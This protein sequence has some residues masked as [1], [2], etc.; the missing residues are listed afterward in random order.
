MCDPSLLPYTA[1][2]DDPARRKSIIEVALHPGEY[3][4]AT[5]GQRISTLLGSCVAIT[6]WH[7]HHRIGAMCHY[8]LPSRRRQA[9][10]KFDGRYGEEAM[11][12]LLGG[13]SALRVNLADCKAKLFGGGR[14]LAAPQYLDVGRMNGE[15]A[16]SILRR[17]GIPVVAES[18]F[19]VCYRR[20]RFDVS[21]GEVWMWKGRPLT[22]L[23]GQEEQP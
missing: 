8:V 4:V 11:D 18:L 5:A 3:A 22:K 16:R 14:L 15:A 9:G 10:E 20:L 12:L 2:H 6:L 7:P 19:G 1:S 13:L 23:H 21:T 17:H